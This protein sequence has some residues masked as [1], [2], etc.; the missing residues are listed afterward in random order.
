MAVKTGVIKMSHKV[1]VSN[2]QSKEPYLRETRNLLCYVIREALYIL[3]AEYSSEISVTLTDDE[4]I[5]VINLKH[6]NIDKATDI[7]SFPQYTPEEID[8]FDKNDEVVLGDI[9]I[10]AERARAQ[11]LEYG[12]SYTRE[13]AFLAVHSV[14][15][16]I[17]YDHMSDEEE[18]AM[19]E[20]QKLVLDSIGITR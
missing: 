1:I 4:N 16:L 7:L 6:R 13:L 10:S 9:V 12:H 2:E 17:G 11:S 8:T 20:M 19:C 5:R 18:R 3:G 15:H 14:L